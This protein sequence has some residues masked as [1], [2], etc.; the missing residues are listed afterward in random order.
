MYKLI[1]LNEAEIEM[2]QAYDWYE[3]K[4]IGLGD[5]FMLCI[6]SKMQAILRTPLI[7]QKVYKNIRR[8]VIR[9]F[10]YC[11][12]FIKEDNVIQILSI[13]HAHKNPM[14]FRNKIK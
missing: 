13:F 2:Q 10:P 4:S 12:F 5:D 3:E 9:R 6:D 11:I 14:T 8:A 1:L 7:Y